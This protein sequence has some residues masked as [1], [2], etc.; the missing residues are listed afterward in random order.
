RLHFGGRHGVDD[1]LR[2]VVAPQHNVDALAVELVRHRLHARTAHADA[3]TDGIGP[4]VVCDHGDLGAVARITR[5]RLDLDQSLTD[6]RHLEGEQL[7]H[8]LRR[9]ATHEQLPPTNL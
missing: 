8:E 4:R 7:D 9:G 5:C 6:F 3:G 2:R 1:E